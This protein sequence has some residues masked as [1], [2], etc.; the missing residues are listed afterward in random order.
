VLCLAPR[1]RWRRRRRERQVVVAVGGGA[2]LAGA[3]GAP[4]GTT[5]VPFGAERRRRHCALRPVRLGPR[6]L[7]NNNG[8]HGTTCQNTATSTYPRDLARIP[9]QGIQIVRPRIFHA[10]PRQ[11]AAQPWHTIG[12]WHNINYTYCLA[13][14]FW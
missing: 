6:S 8:K 13:F 14:F 9:N 1:R 10:L 2:L 7:H 12:P 4:R 5:R 3:G 11:P